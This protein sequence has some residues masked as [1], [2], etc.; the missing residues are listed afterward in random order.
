MRNANQITV[1]NLLTHT[2]GIDIPN[3]E[4]PRNKSYLEAAAINWIVK[5]VTKNTEKKVGKWNYNNANFVLLAGIIRKTTGSSYSA[6]VESR[7][8]RPLNLSHTFTSNNFSRNRQTAI[9][10]TLLWNRFNYFNAQGASRNQLSQVPGAG[11]LYSTPSDFYKIL[12]G[13]NDGQILTAKQFY[14]LTHLPEKDSTYSGGMYIKNG[15]QLKLAYGNVHNTYFGNWVQLTSDNQNGIVMF[16]N[17][18]KD[19]TSRNKAIGYRILKHIKS[20]T[21]LSK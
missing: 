7:I 19:G 14:A 13:M 3:T 9:S 21:F 20:G 18:T 5:H 6:N 2:S 12:A 1:S 17:Q 8:A 10:Y 4:Q 11:N 16:L 15:G